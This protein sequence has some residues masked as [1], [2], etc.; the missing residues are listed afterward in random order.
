MKILIFGGNRFVGKLVTKQLYTA[1]HDITLINRTG[2]SPVPCS[3]IKCDRNDSDSLRSAIGDTFFDCVIDMC[4]YN[5]SQAVITT[6]IL[7]NNT[8]KYIFISSIAVYDNTDIY[9]ISIYATADGIL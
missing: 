1:G 5:T 9:P 4:L 7:K 6:D 2:T 3:V 8:H